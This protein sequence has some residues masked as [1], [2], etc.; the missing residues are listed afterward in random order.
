MNGRADGPQKA[1][2]LFAAALVTAGACATAPH[3]ESAADMSCGPFT[4][5]P[6]RA[7]LMVR[8]F[9]TEHAA[10]PPA[11]VR[12]EPCCK[13]LGGCA[14]KRVDAEGWVLLE[15]C[16]TGP[17]NDVVVSVDTNPRWYT[18]TPPRAVRVCAAIQE[19][20]IPVARHPPPAYSGSSGN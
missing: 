14:P 4:E 12:V 19:V 16:P 1:R 15:A 10:V 8:V 5:L 9:E 6:A 7:T 2:L 3:S 17:A 18:Y 20:S 11:E 13:G